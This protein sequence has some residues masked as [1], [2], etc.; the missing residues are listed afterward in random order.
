MEAAVLNGDGHDEATEEHVVGRVQIVD[1][2]VLS[3]K[4]AGFKFQENIKCL[5][6]RLRWK[7]SLVL[8]IDFNHAAHTYFIIFFIYFRKSI[9]P[10]LTW[11]REEAGQPE[12]KSK[13]HFRAFYKI[14][15]P[16]SEWAIYLSTYLFTYLFIYL[17]TI[18]LSRYL[19]I[20]LS[21]YLSI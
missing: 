16:N 8:K 12:Y 18:H 19:S 4:R 13:N 7:Y 21:I 11:S 2:H 15:G 5:K 9:F 1:C 17:S 14:L 10:S 3:E 20:H 6:Y